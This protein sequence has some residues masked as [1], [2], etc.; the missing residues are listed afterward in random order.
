MM[1]NHKCDNYI[2]GYILN[3]FLRCVWQVVFNDLALSMLYI[4]G[5]I[6]YWSGPCLYLFLMKYMQETRLLSS[7]TV[8]SACVCG[9]LVIY[10][11]RK[12]LALSTLI[13]RGVIIFLLVSMYGMLNCCCYCIVTWVTIRFHLSI[14]VL[15]WVMYN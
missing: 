2:Y 9:W 3:V 10:F 6:Q 15:E 7:L 11:N 4:F 8:C 12:L 14:S 5:S 1:W 13:Y